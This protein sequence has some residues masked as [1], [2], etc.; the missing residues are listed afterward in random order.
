MKKIIALPYDSPEPL[1]A[2]QDVIAVKFNYRLGPFGN[3][4][5]PMNVNGQPKSNFAL[6]DTRLAMKWLFLNSKYL[7]VHQI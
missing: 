6:L 4:Y 2:E 1:V 5:F 7:M 3:W